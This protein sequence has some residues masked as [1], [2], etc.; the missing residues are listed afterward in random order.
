MIRRLLRIRKTTESFCYE[1]GN[2]I[3]LENPFKD[4]VFFKGE[5]YFIPFEEFIKEKEIEIIK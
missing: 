2:K 1:L 3:N 4:Y 5:L